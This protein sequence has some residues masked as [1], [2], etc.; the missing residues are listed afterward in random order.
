MATKTT[1]TANLN[2]LDIFESKTTGK[3]RHTVVIKGK[4]FTSVA[5]TEAKNMASEEAAKHL[6]RCGISN[7]SGPYPVDDEGKQMEM[8]DVIEAV[9]LGE[10]LAYHCDYD[11]TQS[12]GL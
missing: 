7:V 11:F 12:F 3:D 10:K 4:D 2:G 1:K 6:G 9:K 8:E 5:N